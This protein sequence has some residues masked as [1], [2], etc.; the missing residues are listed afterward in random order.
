MEQVGIRHPLRSSWLRGSDQ[1]FR[2][3]YCYYI[4]CPACGYGEPDIRPDAEEYSQIDPSGRCHCVSL[5]RFW[6]SITSGSTIC[7][8]RKS[9]SGLFL[10]TPIFMFNSFIKWIPVPDGKYAVWRTGWDINVVTPS[11]SYDNEAPVFS[12]LESARYVPLKAFRGLKRAI[13][14]LRIARSIFIQESPLRYC[15]GRE[16]LRLS[17][18]WTALVTVGRCGSVCSFLDVIIALAKFANPACVSTPLVASTGNSVRLPFRYDFR[19]LRLFIRARG[20]HPSLPLSRPFPVLT[21]PS[22]CSP[23]S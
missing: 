1:S 15:G 2:V 14:L 6:F 17:Q 13:Q 11:T 10:A 9:T 19:L 5:D 3:R 18:T 12:Y 22:T 7:L 8:V 21:V 4:E 23:S 16:V 20:C